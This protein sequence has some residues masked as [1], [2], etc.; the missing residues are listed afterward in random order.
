V[1]YFCAMA[2]NVADL[3]EHAVD[4]APRR[5]A[6]VCGPRRATFA[7]LESRSNR[8]AHH[9]AAQGIGPG[10][11]VGIYATNSLE[12]IETMLGIYKV[13]ARAVH[14]NFRYTEP[15]LEYLLD[16]ADVVALVHDRSYSAKVAA[17]LPRV[18][19]V[20]HQVV[21]EDG[22]DEDAGDAVHYEDA[23]AACSPERDFGPREPDDTYLLYTGG[24]TGRPKG[25][26]WRHE[27]VWRALGGGVD[28]MTG[29]PLPDEW[30]QSREGDKSPVVRLCTA[31]L[32]HGQGQWAMFGALFSA[33]TVVVLPKFDADALWRAVESE[34]VQVV[35]LVGDAMARPVIEAYHAGGYDGSSLVAVSSTAALFSPAVKRAFLETFPN[36]FLTDAIGS[37]ETGFS[38]IGLVSDPGEGARGP[39][40]TAQKNTIIIDDDNRPI[41]PSSTRTGRLARG[42]YLPLGY[43][44]DAERT[45]ALFVE[46]DGRRYTVPGDYAVYE[47][48]GDITLLGRGDQCVNTGGE[49]VYP[50]E[51][52][53]VLKSHPGV[54]DAVVIG[55]ADERLGQRVGAVVQWREGAEQDAVSLDRHNREHLSGYKV[56]RS[57]WFVEAIERTPPG[58]PDYPAA[59]RYAAAHPPSAELAVKAGRYRTDSTENTESTENT[60]DAA[61]HAETADR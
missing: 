33:H 52:E 46:I 26:M 60:Q 31:P 42:G 18:P 38:G 16:N 41:D 35:A 4:V 1:F 10:D 49:K 61:D 11:H 40:V 45:A 5:T 6:V 55:L 36:T 37:S 50:E 28:F 22:S 25:V 34:K 57:Y 27:D 3:F 20:R 14:I 48:G 2:L 13:R 15:E 51:V 56:P 21:I 9:L 54:F 19:A 53:G 24:T 39:R 17:V 58:K 47:S 29:E 12:V 44:K 30:V 8:M 23:L 32:T 59:R 7:E 43:Y